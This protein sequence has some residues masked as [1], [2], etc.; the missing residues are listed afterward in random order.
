MRSNE[1]GQVVIIVAVV[2]MVTLFFLAVIIDGARLMV[3]RQELKRAADA[4][5]KAGLVVV[6]DRMVTQV[7]QA[8]TAQASVTVTPNPVGSTPG[9]TPTATSSSG[10][11]YDWLDDDHRATLVAPPM[12]TVVATQSVGY[13]EMNGLGPSNPLVLEFDV[14][15]PYQYDPGGQHLKIHVQI[16]RKVTVMFASLLGIEE[17]V[18][19]GESKQS[20]PQR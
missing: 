19:S 10:K 4:A 2:L 8:Q 14:A 9:V 17:G 1:Q 11:F 18:L 16:R 5:A 15:F 20:I 3:E 12:Q 13:A 6:G 7:I